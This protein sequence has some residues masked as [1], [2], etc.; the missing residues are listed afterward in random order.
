VS[1]ADPFRWL[2]NDEDPSVR[3][4]IHAQNARTDRAL[5]AIPGR[6]E[7]RD[8]LTGL[9]RAGTS[10]GPQVA[11]SRVFTVER[12]GELDQAVLV[13]R[14]AT[15][16]G[17]ARTIVDP[18]SLTGDPTTAIDW[19]CPSRDGSLVAFGTSQGGDERSTLQIVDVRTGEHHLDRI[20]ET[21][22]ASVAWEPNG[23]GFVYTRYPTDDPAAA[24]RG[25]LRH[26]FHHQIGRAWS[27]D[28]LVWDA[29][30]DPTAWTSISL[31]TDG[32]WMLVHISVGW[33]R[34]DVHLVDRVWGA[35]SVL[36]EGVDARTELEI[37]G[38]Q[39]IG[40]TTLDAD[41]GR[42]VSAPLANPW[43]DHW[44]T[45]VPESD[46]VIESVAASSASLLVVSTE[47]AV[48]RLDRYA[49]DGGDHHPVALPGIGSVV[50]VDASPDRDEAF[51]SFTSFATP[52]TTFRWRGDDNAAALTE[53]SHLGGAVAADVVVEQVRYSSADGTSVPMFLIRA[54]DTTPGPQTPCILTGYGGFSITMSPAFSPIAAEVSARRGVYAVAGLRGGAEEG[55]AWHRAGMLDR[56]QNTFDDFLAAA[57]WLVAEGI[58]SREHLAIRGGS[59]GGLLM[60]AAITQRPDVCRAAHIAVPLLD[61]VRY[62]EFLL[63][64]LWVPEY[65]DPDD[66]DQLEWL[67]AYSPYHHVVDGTCYPA[68]L[69]TTAEG[70]SRVHP[71]HARKMA[72]R[73]QE[74]SSCQAENP[75]LLRE[76]RDAGHGQGKPVSRQAA[77]LADALGFLL[78]R[79]EG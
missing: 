48:A 12:W 70:D 8:R 3:S 44:C 37:V 45:I 43:H 30:P 33:S 75:V 49:H 31:S 47:R 25:E 66:P 27:T 1:I 76:E 52:P 24:D 23:H 56:K 77:D 50:G 42:V 79:I 10:V 18:H 20:P 68:T 78:E 61:M 2:E 4:W 55:E 57:D 40:M 17:R 41:R 9:L 26:V 34:T 58:T 32:R 64:R 69:L 22:A 14:S 13:V 74:A 63:G 46:A 19:F 51:L 5:S 62:P 21:R 7:L 54:A 60:G 39:V 71:F 35:R 28:P 73:L 15:A 65:G 6:Q 59:N 16:P 53:W 11:G 29:L 72:A 38:D 36:I 67:L